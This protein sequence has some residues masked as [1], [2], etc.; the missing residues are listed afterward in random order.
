MAQVEYDSSTANRKAKKVCNN[1]EF[2]I[3]ACF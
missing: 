1:K 2:V 3:N